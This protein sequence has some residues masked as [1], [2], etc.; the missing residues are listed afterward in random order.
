MWMRK[1]SQWAKNL[2]KNNL[3][4]WKK[5]LPEQI[6]ERDY[7]EVPIADLT[8]EQKARIRQETEEKLARQTNVSKNIRVYSG[9]VRFVGWIVVRTV[10]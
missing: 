9:N 1:N 6:P 7:G 8:H 3:E 2:I 5:M 10:Y 4:K